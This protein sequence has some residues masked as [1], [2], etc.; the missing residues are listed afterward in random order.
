MFT[1]RPYR[2]MIIAARTQ[3]AATVMEP[4][5]ISDFRINGIA[6]IGNTVKTAIITAQKIV[7]AFPVYLTC[8]IVFTYNGT[9]P[10]GCT[11]PLKKC[12]KYRFSGLFHRSWIILLSSMPIQVLSSCPP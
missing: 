10:V 5:L 8:F 11:K 2:H 3:K 6:R 1:D 4:V 12:S 9:R 7:I